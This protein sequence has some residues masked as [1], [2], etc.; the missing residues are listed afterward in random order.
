[1]EAT[2][3]TRTMW[4]PPRITA[5]T[6]AASPICKASGVSVPDRLADINFQGPRDC[7]LACPGSSGSPAATAWMNDL[8]EL[9]I[10]I[11]SR[12]RRSRSSAA[13]ISKFSPACLAEA[14]ARVNH[15]L[16]AGHT[17]RESTLDRPRKAS[18]E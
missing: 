8:R 18:A 10:R 16:R 3:C 6:A 2:S 9:P 13:M 15:D 4:T 17:S 1:M 11:G 7:P 5:T 12:N 14:K